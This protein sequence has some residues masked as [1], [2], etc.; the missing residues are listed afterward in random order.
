MEQGVSLPENTP[1]VMA[2]LRKDA[3]RVL[4]KG[5]RYTIRLDGHRIMWIVNPVGRKALCEVLSEE[6]T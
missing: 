2:L 6:T 5:T 3:R 1:N 4:P